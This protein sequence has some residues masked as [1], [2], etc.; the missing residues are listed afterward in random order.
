MVYRAVRNEDGF[1]EKLC[2]RNTEGRL[3]ASFILKKLLNLRQQAFYEA[4][5]DEVQQISEII[6]SLVVN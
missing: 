4:R 2:Q 3:L 5:D 6:E 1:E